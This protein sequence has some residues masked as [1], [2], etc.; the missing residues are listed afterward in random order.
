MIQVFLCRY[1]FTPDSGAVKTQ[2]VIEGENFGTDTSLVKVFI[3][4]KKGCIDK[5]EK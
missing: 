1:S 5:C 4:G 3:G 2:M